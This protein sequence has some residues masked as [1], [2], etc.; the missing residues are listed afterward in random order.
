MTSF[1]LYFKLGL[2]HI[3]D[4]QGFDHILFILALCAVYVARD[5]V[6][7]LL[8]V[9]AFTL[10][11][12]LTLALA[13]FEVVQIRSEVIEILIPVTIAFTALVTLIKPK[14][15][16]GKGI[17]L[18]YL[19]ALF[20]GLIHGLGFSNYLRSLL[21]KEASIWQP[22]LAFNVGLEVGQIVIVAAFLLIT[23]LVHLAGMNRKEWTLMVSAFIFGVACMRMLQTKFW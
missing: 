23:S 14:P 9:T 13:T 21:G 7:I 1:E 4:L 6:K 22:L 18:N 15:N 12:S 17:Q 11:H 20:F 8:L 10:G 3:L 19:L 5:W 2:Q 16:S